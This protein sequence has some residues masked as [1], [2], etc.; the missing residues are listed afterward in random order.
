[1]LVL[2]SIGLRPNASEP[3]LFTGS[4]ND[5]NDPA[6]DIPS[7]P[8]TVRLYV[9]DFVYFSEDLEVKRKFEQL[10]SSLITVDFMGTVDWFLGTHFQWSCYD[11]KVS[12]HLSQTGFAAHLV[13]DNNAM[14][15]PIARGYPSTPVPNLTRPTTA[16]CSWN[17]EENIRVWSA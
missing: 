5:P 11:I 12:V 15:P 8:L 3:C 9:D 16:P 2:A 17:G 14:L 7:A 4:T 1:M 10:L 6:A 13:E